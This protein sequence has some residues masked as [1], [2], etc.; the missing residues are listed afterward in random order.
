MS[1][2]PTRKED[3]RWKN[4]AP[5]FLTIGAGAGVEALASVASRRLHCDDEV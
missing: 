3:R 5:E 2:A 4:P 1:P